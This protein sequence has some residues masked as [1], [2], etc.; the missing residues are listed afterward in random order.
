[1]V[2]CVEKILQPWRLKEVTELQLSR[3]QNFLV[4]MDV[5]KAHRT[6]DVLE[7]LEAAKLSACFCSRQLH[8]RNATFRL[9]SEPFGEAQPQ[10]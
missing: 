3:D 9:V 8:I 2:R 4:I 10:N 7:V 1:M 5:F 6:P